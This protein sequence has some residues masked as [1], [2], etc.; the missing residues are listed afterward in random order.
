MEISNLTPILIIAGVVL[1]SLL[2]VGMILARLY[3]RASKE[4]SFVR[5]GFGG[6]MVIMNGGALVLPVLHEVVPVNMRTLRLVVSRLNQQALITKDRMRVDVTTEFY[7]R[8][9]PDQA[10]IAFAAQTL[11][12]RTMSPDDLKDL[13]EGKFVDSLRAVAAEMAM[14]ELH[15]KRTDFVQKVQNAVTGDLE[16]N[17]LELETVSLTALDQTTKEHFNPDNAFDAQGLTKLTETIENKKKIRNDIEQHTSVEIRKKNLEAEKQRLEIQKNEEFAKATQKREIANQAAQEASAMAKEKSDNDRISAEAQIESQKQIETATIKANR[18]VE[19][20]KILNEQSVTQ[21]DIDREKA[22]EI[23]NQD[24][25]IVVA[26]KSKE[27]SKAEKEARQSEAEAVAAAER[28]TTARETEIANRDKD[29]AVIK[30]TEKAEQD[31]VGIK[32]AADAKKISALDEAEAIKTTAQ[33]ESDAVIIKAKADEEKYRV[34]A[35]GKEK[36]NEAENKLSQ[37]IIHMRIQLETIKHASSIVEA[38]VKPIE[39]IESMKVVNI[40]G[41]GEVVGS[42]GSGQQV[43]GSGNSESMSDQLINSLLKY[44]GVAP[45]VD[46]IL[47]E[48]DL[49]VGST[50]GIANIVK[51]NSEGRDTKEG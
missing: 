50:H 11:G 43:Q 23:S 39:A 32:V 41:L 27:R 8:V 38:S 49:D 47:K 35:E 20:E 17:G 10:A 45:I 51:N 48:V 6:Q 44:R 16:K 37:E 30:A 21:K 29:I 36:L 19:E 42:G 12:M 9:K 46:S 25:D 15:E 40:G 31:A 18:L 24:R 7:L 26:E 22:I 28:V 5:T 14:E 33:A 2:I 3:K 1:L 4:I 13:M 34:E